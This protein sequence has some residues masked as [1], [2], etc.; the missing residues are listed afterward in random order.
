MVVTKNDP[1]EI[2]AL[3]SYFSKEFEMKDLG[4]LKF[5][6]GIKVSRSHKGIFFLKGNILVIKHSHFNMS[7]SEYTSARGFKIMC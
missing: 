1:K 4:P 2:K 6:L 3:Q 5:F 7:T